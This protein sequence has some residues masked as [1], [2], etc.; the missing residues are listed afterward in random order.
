MTFF[1]DMLTRSKTPNWAR[2]SREE[3]E[4]DSES[5][6]T[7][8]ELEHLFAYELRVANADILKLKAYNREE[9]YTP[10]VRPARDEALMTS[11]PQISDNVSLS[12]Q[13]RNRKKHLV[14]ALPSLVKATRSTHNV[15]S[16]LK[17]WAARYTGTN[18]P[19][20]AS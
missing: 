17:H 18:S 9:R 1:S 10:Q 13:A 16:F 4:I 2:K 14:R 11:I 5:N 8:E 12:E 19:R 20:S 7:R 3:I 15:N 6:V